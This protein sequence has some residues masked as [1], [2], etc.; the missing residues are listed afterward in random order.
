MV[1][2][3]V[4]HIYGIWR[5]RGG[6]RFEVIWWMQSKPQEGG[7]ILMGKEGEALTICIL[8]CWNFATG[9]CKRFYRIPLFPK[10]LLF[11]LFCIYW[12]WQSQK[13][14]LEC[15]KVYDINHIVAVISACTHPC[16][17]YKHLCPQPHKNAFI[18]TEN[19]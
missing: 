9:Y 4:C 1:P 2:C 16:G 5:R 13:C 18:A 12:D 3:H 6:G 8:L 19:T 15:P 14:K 17:I 11:H 7:A 10:F